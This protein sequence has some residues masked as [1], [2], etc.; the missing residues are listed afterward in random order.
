M[1]RAFYDLRSAREIMDEAVRK[2][3]GD[4]V[5]CDSS[6]QLAAALSN[7]DRRYDAVKDRLEGTPHSVALQRAEAAY[8]ALG[9]ALGKDVEPTSSN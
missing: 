9:K 2:L 5:D 6:L 8:T 4:L 1:S 3:H 7:F